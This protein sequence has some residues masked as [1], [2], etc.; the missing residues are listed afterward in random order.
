MSDIVI[1]HTAKLAPEDIEYLR[2]FDAILHY[3]NFEIPQLMFSNVARILGF[4]IIIP[5][6]HRKEDR[7]CLVFNKYNDVYP[8]EVWANGKAIFE[9]DGLTL[10]IPEDTQTRVV[11][12]VSRNEG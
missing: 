7:V 5:I 3:N 1:Y 12:K 4:R 8:V 10:D 2:S 11:V 9:W 6:D